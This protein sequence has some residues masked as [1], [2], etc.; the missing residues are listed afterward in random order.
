VLI[1]FSWKR[2]QEETEEFDFTIGSEA[3]KYRFANKIRR[4][5]E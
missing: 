4:I 2:H 5:I 3:F 1:N